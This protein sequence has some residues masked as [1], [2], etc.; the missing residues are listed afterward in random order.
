MSTSLTIAPT[1]TSRSA[2][3]IRR[4]FTVSDKDQSPP[5]SESAAGPGATMDETTLGDLMRDYSA[6]LLSYVTKLMWS[7]RQLAEDI[8]QET[9]L[10]LWRRPNVLANGHASVGPWLFTVARNLVND[11]RRVRANKL[12]EINV[13]ELALLSEKR[14]MIEEIL[15]A[16]DMRRAM[17]K[18][19]HQHRSVLIQ[20]YYYDRSFDDVAKSLRI[21]TGTVKSRTHYALRSLRIVLTR[22]G[23]RS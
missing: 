8:V 20:V 5:E 18:L 14:D 6:P 10:R 19:S 23:I 22:L 2:L 17:A 16:Q 4:E 11:H 3:M 7:D 13:A 1:P 21:P 15:L 9:F 12:T